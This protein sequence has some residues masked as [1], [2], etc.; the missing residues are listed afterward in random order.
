[1][2]T[3]NGLTKT[4]NT[5]AVA[6][7]AASGLGV[8]I[9]SK[10]VQERFEKMLGKKS[11]GFL[12][13]L[14]TLVN[15][16]NLLQ[17]ANPTSVL[18][19]AAT[20]ASLDL[21]V[22]P[23]LGLAWIVPYGNGAQ[24]QLGY[25]GAIALAMRSGQMK[26]IVMTE[27]YEGECKCWNRFTETFEFGDR[28]SDNIIG[29]YARF[30]TVNGFV[31]ATF[32]TKEEVLKHAKRFSKSF[33]RGPWQTDFDAMAKKTVLLSIIKTYAPMSIEMQSAF[34]SDGKV[35]TFNE[36]TGQEEFIEAEVLDAQ[37]EDT[38][39]VEDTAD[40]RKVDTETGEL[41]PN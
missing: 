13:S 40:G 19:A 33:N 37:N 9:G 30:E 34:E 6:A 28:V 31:K 12:S 16:N 41:F 11:A 32:W 15:N 24:F 7:K 39:F 17:K 10:S 27:V 18:A 29:Y 21:P 2:A 20:A 35:A 38:A 25:R 36:T 4:N 1:M 3:V 14:L 8:M 26:S 23:S 5:N 22:N